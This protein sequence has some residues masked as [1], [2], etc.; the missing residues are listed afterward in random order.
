MRNHKLFNFIIGFF[1]CSVLTGCASTHV[2]SHWL[3]DANQTQLS[4][5]GGWVE[6]KT[7][8]STTLGELIAV[9]DDTLFVADPMLHAINNKDITSA[10]LVIYDKDSPVETWSFFGAL[11]TLSNGWCLFYTMPMWIIGGTITGSIYSFDPIIDYPHSPLK[12][13]TPYARYPQGLPPDLDRMK[14]KMKMIN[15]K[16]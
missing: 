14:I 2:P 6:L 3:T 10:R 1:L 16:K 9:A 5:Y 15:K 4:P 13:F 12:Y 7:E 11:S 8:Q